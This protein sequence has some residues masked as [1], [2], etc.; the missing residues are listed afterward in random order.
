MLLLQLMNTMCADRLT[1]TVTVTGQAT[2]RILDT[3]RRL[4]SR[5]R[6]ATADLAHCMSNLRPAL[7]TEPTH[8]VLLM[9]PSTQSSLSIDGPC[10]LKQ[11]PVSLWERTHLPNCPLQKTKRV[12]KSAPAILQVV[13][14]K[15]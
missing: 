10:D 9:T 12:C 2:F 14:L 8:S 6:C 4:P 5:C 13:E 11:L 3:H 15:R 7:V 1:V